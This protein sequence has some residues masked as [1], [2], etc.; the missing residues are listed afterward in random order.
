MRNARRK[1]LLSGIEIYGTCKIMGVQV[2]KW[3]VPRVST[4]MCIYLNIRSV[5]I[6]LENYIAGSVYT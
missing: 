6:K 1:E 5:F 4:K 2:F 3:K